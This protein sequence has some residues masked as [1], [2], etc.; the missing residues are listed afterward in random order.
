MF[1]QLLAK[2]AVA[3]KNEGIPYMVIGGQAVLLYGE[4]RLT[5]DIDVTLGLEV[6]RLPVVKAM[7][8]RLNFQPLSLDDQFTRETM[9]FPCADPNTGIRVDFIFSFSPYEQQAM[10]RVKTVLLGGASVR[11]ASAEDV[12]IHKVIAGRPRDIED[13][14]SIL[15]KNKN[16][17]RDY[18]QDWLTAF[19]ETLQEPFLKR[20]LEI[21]PPLS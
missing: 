4:P 1:E 19:S 8:E 12:V 11:F 14:R 2:I 17:D 18:I 21:E 15:M 20:F 16:L 9:V 3:L 6:E 10:E 13:V 5:K 7:I